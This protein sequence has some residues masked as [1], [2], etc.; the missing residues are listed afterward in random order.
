[1]RCAHRL[2]PAAIVAAVTLV[3]AFAVAGPLVPPPGPISPTNKPLAEIEPRVAVNA[4]N[5]PGDNDATPSLFKITEPGSYYLTN[6][7]VG[8]AGKHGV[9]I[10]ASDVTLDLNGFSL[11]GVP[12]SLDGVHVSAAVEGVTIRNGAAHDWGGAGISGFFARRAIVER[13]RAHNNGGLGIRVGDSSVV[14]ACVVRSNGSSG[15]LTGTACSV[16]DTVADTNTGNGLFVGAGSTVRG[17][18]A[19]FNTFAGI[20]AGPSSSVLNCAAS[21]N[22]QSGFEIGANSVVQ[23]CTATNNGSDGIKAGSGSSVTQCVSNQNSGDGVSIDANSLVKDN[24]C[25]L[26]NAAGVH[27]R[28]SDVHVEGNTATNNNQGFLVDM[29]GNLIVRNSASGNVSNFA[30]APSNTVGAI[31]T[32]GAIATNLNPHANY[33][34]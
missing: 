6:D 12:G 7:I 32:S 25:S 18:V 2:Y 30:I 31:V 23:V 26:N 17:C 24:A 9:E 10:T 15:V 4:A 14:Q 29:G 33:S 27:V 5:T 34:F 21:H 22:S 19:T 3:G 8:E 28:G 13:I 16:V 20:N 11:V 1:M